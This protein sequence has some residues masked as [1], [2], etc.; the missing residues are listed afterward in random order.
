[1]INPV[2]PVANLENQGWFMQPLSK[3]SEAR[4]RLSVPIIPLKNERNQGHRRSHRRHRRLFA[5][6]VAVATGRSQVTVLLGSA[7]RTGVARRR[8]WN[9]GRGQK[10]CIYM[11]I[12]IY[13]INYNH[14][15]WVNYYSLTWI[16]RPQNG[17]IHRILTIIYGEVVVRWL[18]FTQTLFYS[19]FSTHTYDYI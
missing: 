18:S 10:K 3:Q 17:I 12:Y 1:M 13:I 15:I 16:V 7:W 14:M 4:P 11:Y 2:N 9:A 6:A 8:E 5:G 19:M